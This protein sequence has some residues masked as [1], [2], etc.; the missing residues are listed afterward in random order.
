MAEQVGTELLGKLGD[1]FEEASNSHQ[2][3]EPPRAP[4]ASKY[5][6]AYPGYFARLAPR[7]LLTIARNWGKD[8]QARMPFWTAVYEHTSQPLAR[9][10]V[11]ELMCRA[12]IE[13][14]DQGEEAYV[15]ANRAL[16]AVTA[17]DTS[18]DA[19]P[20]REQEAI[21]AR[22]EEVKASLAPYLELPLPTTET[23]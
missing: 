1:T 16:G 9:S 4:L 13:V 2:D 21:S 22:R 11:A 23:P 20:G 14:D 12:T 18:F 8:T 5:D 3:G 7:Q 19:I 17:G 6:G 10:R 15:W